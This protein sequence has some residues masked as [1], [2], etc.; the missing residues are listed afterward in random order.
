MRMPMTNRIRS[1]EPVMAIELFATALGWMAILGGR[2]GL[3]RLTFGHRSP[4]SARRVI[5]VAGCPNI[6]IARWH[7]SLAQQLQRSA[8]G[9]P[10]T[11]VDVQLDLGHMT[12]FQHAVMQA[13]RQ[14]SGGE[15]ATYGQLAERVSHRRAARAVGR[16]MAT[17]PVPLVVPCHRV[18]A[19]GGRLGGYSAPQGT[20]MKRRLLYLEGVEF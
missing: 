10:T 9:Q 5:D 20:T 7:P 11:L 13:C 17:N 15:V 19:A 14:I 16:V 12:P 1:T 2:K 3:R 4:Q 6:D 18:I 8:E